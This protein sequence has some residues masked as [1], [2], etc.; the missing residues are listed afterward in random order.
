MIES[1]VEAGVPFA[2]FA[3]DEEFGQNPG[4]RDY[5]ETIRTSYVMAVPKTTQ[6]TDTTGKTVQ[7]NELAGLLRRN[8]W[9]RR[10]RGIGSKGFRVYDWALTDSADPD[11]QYMIRRSIDDGELAFYHCYNPNRAGFGELV[12]VAGARWP[13]EECFG[14]GKNEVGLDHYQVRTWEAWH[15]HIT[16][17]MLAHTFLAVTAHKAKKR[18]AN[19]PNS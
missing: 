19:E 15:R 10:S 14:A 6:F 3:A 16:F 2:W 7:L 17:A 1:T 11:H 4:L 13:I 8:A 5:L 12:H 18:G 9:Q